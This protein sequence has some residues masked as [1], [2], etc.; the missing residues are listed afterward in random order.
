MLP[1]TKQTPP[2]LVASYTKNLA[3]SSTH[4]YSV[5]LVWVL[6]LA[7]HSFKDFSSGWVQLCWLVIRRSSLCVC[8]GDA[9]STQGQ[10]A[11]KWFR[12]LELLWSNDC[13][14]GRIS[15]QKLLSLGFNRLE[16]SSG[17]RGHS[18]ILDSGGPNIEQ[19]N[20]TQKEVLVS[21][22]I[23]FHGVYILAEEMDNSSKENHI[24][25]RGRWRKWAEQ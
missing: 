10:R 3:K 1:T 25:Q 12:L 14:P 15:R 11:T 16:Q 21:F 24:S 20:I 6:V 23:C 18:L 8:T 5:E 17:E 19:K 13:T 22:Q 9:Q 2:S 7:S 4:P